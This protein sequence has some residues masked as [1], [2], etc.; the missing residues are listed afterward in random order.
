MKTEGGQIVGVT[1]DMTRCTA[2]LRKGQM[3]IISRALVFAD[4]NISY[5]EMADLLEDAYTLSYKDGAQ[6]GMTAQGWHF[7]WENQRFTVEKAS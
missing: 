3:Q 5:R 4:R 1:V 6:V 2:Q 7:Y